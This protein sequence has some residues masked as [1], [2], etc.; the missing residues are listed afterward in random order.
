MLY[1][2]GINFRIKKFKRKIGGVSDWNK[3]IINNYVI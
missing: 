3:A 1:F 2:Q